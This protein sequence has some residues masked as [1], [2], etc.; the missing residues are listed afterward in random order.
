MSLELPWWFWPFAATLVLIST[1]TYLGLHVIQRKV[2]FVDLAL[3]QIAALGSTVAFLFGFD[4][5]DPTTYWVSLAFAGLGALVF[6]YTRTHEDRVP[7][8]AIIGLSFAIASALSILLSAENPHGAEHLRD[9]MAGSI[10]VVTPREAGIAALLYGA[11][12]AFH[13]FF[14]KPFH[15]ISTDPEQAAKNGLKVARWDLAFY[16]TFAFVIT[17]SVKIAGVLLVFTLL[18][19]PAVCGALFTENFR[20][21]LFIGWAASIAAAIGGL[22][23]SAHFDWPPAPSIICVYMAILVGCAAAAQL[24]HAPNRATAAVRIA[25][26]GAVIGAL[27]GGLVLFLSEA[28][29]H[30]H[31]APEH[32]VGL[33]E[34]E[35]VHALSD[36]HDNVRAKAAEELGRTRDR[37]HVEA[38]IA[39]LKD[40]S[41]AVKEK[42][43]EALGRI[44]DPAAIAAL[45]E[46]LA[47]P[48][49]DEW[50]RLREA[51]ALALLGSANGLAELEKIAVDGEARVLRE[52]AK[53]IAAAIKSRNP[54]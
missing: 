22:M 46:A 21:R 40:P 51:E 8:E 9:I 13:W 14:R 29:E 35:L 49:E 39:R 50:V 23:L 37:A 28:R 54:K 1:H 52:E 27:L 3:A 48:D 47:T 42:T 41:T 31:G 12:L 36:E 19:A 7:Q 44:G 43:A 24:L 20:R 6:S 53:K 10:L 18:I 25:A 30:S 16:G 33:T 17:S 45:E 4:L 15:A 34:K 5:H 2:I 38:L 32:G 26:S 11:I